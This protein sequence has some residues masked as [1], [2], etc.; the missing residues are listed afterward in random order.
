Q[1]PTPFGRKDLDLGGGVRFHGHPRGR[2]RRLVRVQ[3]A[4]PAKRGEPPLLLATARHGEVRRV[5]GPVL[6]QPCHGSGLDR[7][8]KSSRHQPTAPSICSS[9]SRL[10]SS[11]YSIGS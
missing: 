10:S 9:I 2:S 8:L 7:S 11:A 1:G 6:V 4:Q 5:V 3:P